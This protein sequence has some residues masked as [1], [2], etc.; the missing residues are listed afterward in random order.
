MKIPVTKHLRTN[1]RP[2]GRL[3]RFMVWGLAST[4][5]VWGIQ[6][7]LSRYVPPQAPT[8]EISQAKLLDKDQNASASGDRLVSRTSASARAMPNAHIAMF[9]FYSVALRSLT[10]PVTGLKEQ[11]VGRSW[12]LCRSAFLSALFVR[13]PPILA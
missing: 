8:H 5:I 11:K 6:Y 1:T 2:F 12:G 4:I 7:K 10:A 9:L 3:G 13:P